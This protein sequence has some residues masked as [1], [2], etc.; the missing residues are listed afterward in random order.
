MDCKVKKEILIG[1]HSQEYQALTTR[2]S[3]YVTVKFV[4]GGVFI[5]YLGLLVY[6]K[7]SLYTTSYMWLAV[8]FGQIIAIIAM[9]VQY[10]EFYIAHY[11][12]FYLRPQIEELVEDKSFFYFERFSKKTKYPKSKIPHRFE[13]LWLLPFLVAIINISLK[14]NYYSIVDYLWPIINLSIWIFLYLFIERAYGL[15]NKPLEKYTPDNQ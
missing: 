6:L 12:E 10:E 7:E 3:Y 9:G 14:C 15:L 2:A 13:Y 8:L 5:S 4:I 1:L 11:L